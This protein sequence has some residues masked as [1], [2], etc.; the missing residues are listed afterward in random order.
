MMRRLFLPLAAFIAIPLVLNSAT[1]TVVNTNASG[2]GSLD[3]A[4][5][6]ANANG[7]ADTIAFNI[8]N[9]SL[10]ISPSSALPILSD[11]VTISAATQTGYVGAP[12]VELSGV[13]AGANTAGFVVATSN[14][15]IRALCVNRFN[16]DGIL[17]TNGVGSRVEGCY[18]GVAA[19]GLTRRGNAGAGVRIA[20]ADFGVQSTGTNTIGGELATAHN[21]ISANRYGIW[22]SETTENAILGNIIGA[23][24]TGAFD[25]GNTNQGILCDYL[26]D[27]NFIGGT[28][29]AARNLISGNGEDPYLYAGDGIRFSSSSS[30]AV[31]GN[32]IGVNAAGTY[33]IPNG[34]H[35]VNISYGN[36]NL[37]GGGLPG[38]GNLISGNL[39]HGVNLGGFGEAAAALNY[40]G[41][42]P[43]LPEGN[44]IQGNLIGTDV[45]GQSA[46]PN[47]D[48]G[49][50]IGNIQGNL[51]GG[52]AAGERNVISGNLDHGVQ[53]VGY[54]TQNNQVSGNFIGISLTGALPLGNGYN[55][56]YLSA[57]GNL[58]G[59]TNAGAGNII[60]YNGYSGVVV[61]YNVG[62]AILGNSVYS[63]LNL[64]ID[65]GDDYVT[66]NDP[67]DE[68]TG[69]NDFQNF[70]VLTRVITNATQ[71][72]IT[73]YL[74]S[75]TNLTYRV[76]LFDNDTRNISGYGEGQTLLGFLDLTTDG[77]GSANFTFTN[78]TALPVGHWIT[79]TATDTNGNTSEFSRARKVVQADS[80]DLEVVK[81]DSADPAPRATN[82]FYTVTVT[83]FGPT[84]A[85]GVVLT[86][87]LPA[88]V[89][90]VGATPSQGSVTQFAGVVTCNL[91]ALAD[92]AGASLL[93]EVTGNVTGTVTNLAA[94]T[95]NELESDSSNNSAAQETL[96]GIADV[97]V[98]ITDS[99]DPVTAGQPVT[100]TVV[101]TNLG[102]DAATGASLDFYVDNSYFVVGGSVSQGTLA[103][104]GNYFGCA[105]GTVPA[106]NSATLTV[107]AVPTSVGTN[108]QTAYV[109]TLDYDPDYGNGYAYEQTAAVAGPGVLRFTN[110]VYSAG[111]GAGAAVVTV[112]RSGGDIGTVSANFATADLTAMAA[113]DY[114]ATNGTL[115]FTNGETVKTFLVPLTADGAPECNETVSLRLFNPTGGAVLLPPTNATLHIFDDDFTPGGVVEG[116]SVKFASVIETGN[117]SSHA[118]S[119]SDDGR[120]VAFH[121]YANNL[122][123]GVDWNFNSDVFVRDRLGGSNRLVSVNSTATGTGNGLSVNPRISGNGNRVAFMS[124]A[125]DLATNLISAGY[126]QVFVRDL[127]SPVNRLASVNT[128]GGGGNNSSYLRGLDAAGTRVVFYS[129]AS[130][131]V[132]GDANGQS[133]VFVY[134]VSAGTNLL[135]SMNSS[136]TGSGNGYS[137]RP[138]ISANGRYVVFGSYAS[139]LSS[140]TIATA[141]FNVFRRDLVTGV[142]EL[143]SVKTNGTSGN[144]TS[145]G[146]DLFISADGRYVAFDSYASDLVPGVPYGVAKTLLRDMVAGTTVLISQSTG[147]AV[148]DSDCSVRGLSRDGRYVLFESGATNLVAGLTNGANAIFVRD[149]VAGTTVMVNVNLAGTG[150]GAVGTFNFSVPTGASALSPEGRYVSFVSAA[151]NLVSASKDPDVQDVFLRDLQAGATTLLTTRFGDTN[152]GNGTAFPETVISSNGLAGFYTAASDLVAVENNFGNDV[153]VRAPGDT[154]PELIS[155]VF[156]VTGSGYSF[157]QRVTADGTKVVFAS[158][159]ANLV[160]ND[161]N[162]ATDIFLRDLMTDTTVLVSMNSAGAS[163]A[164]SYSQQPVVGADGRYVAFQSSATDLVAGD[165]NGLDDIFL[166]DTV[167]GTNVLISV[168]SSGSGTG[169]GEST[170]PEITPDGR[171]VVF[172]SGASNLTTN[173]TNGAVY[174]VF[175]RNRTNAVAELVSADA[176]GTG[177]GNGDSYHPVVSTD[178]RYVA[179]ESYASNLGPADSNGYNDVYVR[180][181][182]TGSNIL[183]SPNLAGTSGGNADSFAPIISAD[184]RRVIFQSYATDLT[185]GDTNA[186]SDLFAFDLVTRTLQ[187]VSATPGGTPG[188]HGAGNASVS[189]DGR[190]VA[191]WSTAGN[192]VGN[193]ANGAVDD[194]FVRDLVLNTTVLVSI[195]CGGTGSGNNFSYG[196]E[197]SADG[198]YVS[199]ESQASDLTAGDF[200]A[201]TGNIYRRDLLTGTTVLVSQNRY[202]TGGGNG[203]SNGT[204][205]SANGGTIAFASTAS[206]LIADDA[207]IQQDVFGWTTALVPT[208][209]DLVFAKEASTNQV[210]QYSSV[211]YILTVTNVGSGAATGVAVT[212]P[213][214]AGVN[215]V[216]TSTT[217]GSVTN[218]G[219]LVTASVGSLGPGAGARITVVVAPTATGSIS[220]YAAA[221]ANQSDLTPANNSDAVVITATASVP[222]SLSVT[223]SNSQILI[224]WPSGTSG[225]FGLETTT[226]LVPVIVWLPVTNAVSDNGTL[227]QVL[228]NVNP[229]EPTRFYRLH[230]P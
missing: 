72:L 64:G 141:A 148:A 21:L 74:N 149:T 71:T 194:V 169:N 45:T 214:P 204:R 35:G 91:G 82:I 192:L 18:I 183:C 90:Y 119:L 112:R 94:A 172:Q 7:G 80:I 125:T 3:Q 219:N 196:P 37:I 199:F 117:S 110:A 51:V 41:T 17:I 86:D 63:N 2:P 89:T 25:V 147:G 26:A 108:G 186:D 191:F 159:S 189:A 158:G 118:P 42:P 213:L 77:N 222:P 177:S 83:N 84:N 207:N 104:Y 154:A 5:L 144:N 218:A 225:G 58:V 62:N 111:E 227:K 55:G 170:D 8:T 57:D 52:Y 59:G 135:V 121:S 221:T 12:I 99:P 76:E 113:A 54:S 197:I 229:A 206:D 174:D 190:Y 136:G 182:Q 107:S 115:V 9:L 209:V 155:A 163:S 96:F 95:A 15:T 181:R 66:G 120:Y 132:A 171:F 134:D 67:G 228:L 78:G 176:T 137:D 212:D 215:L 92:G 14:C 220:N 46:I 195:N 61:S 50:F 168:R 142:T 24:A 180:D 16:G 100:F 200:S 198:R 129:T 116:V 97:G 36:F 160:T 34:E 11:P 33:A 153:F 87:T 85:S 150:A 145:G 60:A 114:T 139:D 217:Q 165:T 151:T 122:T 201:G 79:A 10:T 32:Y 39:V 30:N 157:G 193:D 185:T 43:P 173:D 162:S 138:T 102:P 216:S 184:G 175:I 140:N 224:S 126:W 101:L 44:I 48:D 28:N 166:R 152:G 105:F 23:D 164:N 68:D 167:A 1:F 156:G 179:F 13:D 40:T 19:D 130:D 208:A 161:N 127:A 53:I 202:A 4:I 47:E 143:V 29:A 133:D 31:Y 22:L 178:G 73:G 98:S 106:N 187:L 65:L 20:G 103:Q 146:L 69:A 128:G 124:F 75:G 226:N 210:A 70:P 203:F 88:G 56:V 93:V 123:P 38:Q 81:T 188:D 131:L 205:I 27:L 211:N 223:L 230:L 49:V 6:D 109:G